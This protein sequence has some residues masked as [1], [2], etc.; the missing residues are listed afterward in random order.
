MKLLQ[1]L[2]LILFFPV[3]GFAQQHN[4]SY[5]A[6]GNRVKRHYVMLRIKYDTETKDSL[7]QESTSLK[8]YPNPFNEQVTISFES[9]EDL[10]GNERLLLYTETG[11]LL[12]EFR[13]NQK[14]KTIQTQELA[15]GKYILQLI[16][17]EESNSFILIKN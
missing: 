7:Q 13:M 2:I 5:D 4:Y 15:K 3:L 6:S 12:Q 8:A 17:D 9:D 1:V 16:R 14:I 11:Q 10:K